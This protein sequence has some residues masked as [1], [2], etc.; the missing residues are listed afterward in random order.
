MNY[1]QMKEELI[2]MFDHKKLQMVSGEWGFFNEIERDIRRLGYA[3]NLSRNI[4]EKAAEEKVDFLLTHHDSWDFIFGLKEVCN[5]LLKN[6]GITH[7]FFHAPLDDADFGTSASLARD[8]GLCGCKKVM[9]YADIYYGGVVGDMIPLGF[10]EFSEKMADVLQEKIR[11][12]KNNDKKVQRVAVAAGGGNMTTEMRIAVENGCDTYVTGEYVLYSQQYAEHAGINLFVGS[13]TNT[14][15]SGVESM[16]R[17]LCWDTDI[18]LVRI[19]EEN[20]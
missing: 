16:A 2:N 15:I 8:L 17:L 12:Y 11:C 5:S 9:P 20:Y 7:A 1:L 13:H 19:G 10:E 14:E 6:H 3:T 4:I 18:Q